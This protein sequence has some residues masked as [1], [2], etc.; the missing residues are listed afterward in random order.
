MP[1]DDGLKLSRILRVLMEVYALTDIEDR[2]KQLEGDGALNPAHPSIV[3]S[4]GPIRKL[5]SSGGRK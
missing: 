1:I 3:A 5:A 2:L 4:T